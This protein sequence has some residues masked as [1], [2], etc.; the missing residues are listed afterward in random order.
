ACTG[1]VP[2]LYDKVAPSVVYVAA[3]SINPY[4]LADRVTRVV[5]SG[6][7]IGPGGLILTNS[8]VAFGRQSIRVTLHA[9]GTPPAEL[10]GADPIFDLALIRVTPPAGT[11]LPKVTLGDS[12]RLRVG[13]E[14]FAIGNPLGLD[15]TLTRGIVSA[16]NRVLSETPFS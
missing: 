6:F 13:D 9:G 1:P 4:R 2:D 3:T 8:H 7:I 14:V 5:G 15:Q 16:M 10:V 12:D 11:S